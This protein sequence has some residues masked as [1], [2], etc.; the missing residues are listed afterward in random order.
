MAHKGPIGDGQGPSPKS[1]RTGK[2]PRNLGLVGF[3]G[4]RARPNTSWRPYN[5]FGSRDSPASRFWNHF[6]SKTMF[7]GLLAVDSWNPTAAAGGLRWGRPAKSQRSKEHCNQI[8]QNPFRG[9]LCLGNKELNRE[10]TKGRS[11][12]ILPCKLGGSAA[13]TPE[14]L[15]FSASGRA[16]DLPWGSRD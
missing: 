9:K 12:P 15:A 4:K 11:P 5:P 8:R 7:F 1:P 14:K 2:L 6:P 3:G 16:R 13:Q 10:P